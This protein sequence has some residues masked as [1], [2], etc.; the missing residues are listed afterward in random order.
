MVVR[1]LSWG[2]R[3]VGRLGHPA[4]QEYVHHPQH[5]AHRA[6]DGVAGDD[7]VAPLEPAESVRQQYHENHGGGGDELLTRCPP[8]VHRV[9]RQ[10][11]CHPAQPDRHARVCQRV[12]HEEDRDDA[13]HAQPLVA[14]GERRGEH[15]YEREAV[16]HRHHDPRPL[17]ALEAVHQHAAQDLEADGER[18]KARH[19]AEVERGGLQVREVLDARRA[20]DAQQAV[21]AAEEAR[22]DHKAPRLAHLVGRQSERFCLGLHQLLAH[23]PRGP[24]IRH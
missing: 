2:M 14:D 24:G 19:Q 8:L 3:L 11:V 22:P 23:R 12:V 10:K 6:D 9:A 4:E 17:A 15:P 13:R 16:D 20:V 7:E 1:Q 21:Q 5:D 18:A